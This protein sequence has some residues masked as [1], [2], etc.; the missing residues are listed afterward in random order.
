MTTG[1]NRNL[2][3]FFFLVIHSYNESNLIKVIFSLSPLQE[4]TLFMRNV[5][6]FYMI[7]HMIILVDAKCSSGDVCGRILVI[8]VPFLQH[9]TGAGM[10]SGPRK[11]K[12]RL[13]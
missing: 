3:S 4:N 2:S 10:S 7:I 8:R 6:N 11:V 13:S 1:A 12:L 5:R 9:G